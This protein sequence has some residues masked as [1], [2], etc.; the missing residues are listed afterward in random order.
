MG[1]ATPGLVVLDTVGEQ[2]ELAMK[3]NP[4]SSTPSCPLLSVPP[5]RFCL[6]FSQ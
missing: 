6:D 4:V 5:L 1:G 2:A 3:S